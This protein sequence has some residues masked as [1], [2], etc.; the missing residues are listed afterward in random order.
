MCECA[1]VASGMNFPPPP[2]VPR[3]TVSCRQLNLSQCVQQ[4]PAVHLGGRC[5]AR[6]E[7][8]REHVVKCTR[9]PARAEM[10]F[11]S[12]TMYA[13]FQSLQHSCATCR[14]ALDASSTWHQHQVC[15]AR[16]ISRW[17][18][19]RGSISDGSRQGQMSDCW[20]VSN[21]AL[22]LPCGASICYVV[23][24][25]SRVGMA[26]PRIAK[27]CARILTW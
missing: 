17:C 16:G 21:A 3:A 22:G 1:C 7:A 20:A 14:S 2:L 8:G 18:A 25:S 19:R 10:C 13:S 12:S 6:C 24:I 15:K 26:C 27:H 11:T 5:R 9:A 23:L 4:S